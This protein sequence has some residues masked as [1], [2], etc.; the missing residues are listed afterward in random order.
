ME[1]SHTGVTVDWNILILDAFYS[2]DDLV[3]EDF[4]AQSERCSTSQL[5]R[6]DTEKSFLDNTIDTTFSYQFR[7]TSSDFTATVDDGG[8]VLIPIVINQSKGSNDYDDHPQDVDWNADLVS[9]L[10]IVISEESYYLAIETLTDDPD[11]LYLYTDE[12]LTDKAHLFQWQ[13]YASDDGTTWTRVTPDATHIYETLRQRFEVT[14]PVV[15]QRYTMLVEQ[16]VPTLDD[17]SIINLEGFKKVMGNVGSTIKESSTSDTHQANASLAWRLSPDLTLSSNFSL[18][19]GS[20]NDID[21]QQTNSN[22]SLRWTLTEF[23]SSTLNIGETREQRTDEPE[24]IKRSYG[25]VLSSLILPTLDINSALTLSNDYEDKDKTKTRYDYSF[26]TSAILYPDLNASLNLNYLTT[27]DETNGDT[28]KDFSSTFTVTA[29]LFPDLTA[30]FDESY[31]ESRSID[32]SRSIESKILLTWRPSDIL[33][34]NANFIKTRE[35]GQWQP[36]KYNI[37]IGIAPTSKVQLTMGY[38]HSETENTYNIT[39]NWHINDIFTVYAAAR[40]KDPSTGDA[41]T[42]NTILT[43]RF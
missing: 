43:V 6:L 37:I 32:V 1:S 25:I 34:A 3:S 20:G 33:S 14:L 18:E 26:L 31:N 27:K 2:Y 16:L 21:H 29:R 19:D 10:P 38:D 12:D 17:F 24:F 36:E 30:T 13:V 40:Y 23:T 5:A 35:D 22:S 8:F 7:T 39:T 28:K 42:Y 4:V 9:P 11:V 15:T 41:L